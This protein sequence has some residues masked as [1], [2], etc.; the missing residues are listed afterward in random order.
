P[1]AT[2]SWRAPSPS[3]APFPSFR[4]LPYPRPASGE[5]S[6]GPRRAVPRARVRRVTTASSV[7]FAASVG[8]LAGASL[9]AHRGLRSA[10]GTAVVGAVG[11]GA[12]E[13]VARARQKEGEI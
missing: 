5:E 13:A 3:T 11:L 12:S 9:A 4:S 6:P 7:G 10:L 1:A 8:G 2:T